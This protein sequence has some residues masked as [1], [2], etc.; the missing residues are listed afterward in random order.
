LLLDGH[1]FLIIIPV[2]E[3]PELDDVFASFLRSYLRQLKFGL[4][5]M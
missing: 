2:L 1:E 3:D 4:R 5:P